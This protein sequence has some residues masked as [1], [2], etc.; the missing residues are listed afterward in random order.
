[1]IQVEQKSS[2]FLGGIYTAFTQC[3]WVEPE[4]V[5][6]EPKEGVFL[7]QRRACPASGDQHGTE[8]LNVG[9]E[10]HMSLAYLEAPIAPMVQFY[11]GC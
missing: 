5:Y 3:Q 11:T 7:V 2:S 9:A 8:G 4:R 1:M 10:D 6:A